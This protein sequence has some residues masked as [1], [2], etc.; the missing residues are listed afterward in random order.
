V[1][2]AVPNVLVV[3][4]PSV[5]DADTYC[6]VAVHDVEPALDVCPLEHATQPAPLPFVSF[7]EELYVFAGHERRVMQVRAILVVPELLLQ[8]HEEEVPPEPDEKLEL[9]PP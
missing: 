8:E 1:A 9:V 4:P 7:P 2:C 5:T 6:V 3:Y